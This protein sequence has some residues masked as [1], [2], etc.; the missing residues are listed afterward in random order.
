[1]HAG[2]RDPITLAL[3]R[4]LPS[5]NSIGYIALAV[6]RGALTRRLKLHSSRTFIH[7]TGRRWSVFSIVWPRNSMM[8]KGQLKVLHN[9]LPASYHNELVR[10]TMGKFMSQ[11]SKGSLKSGGIE[12]RNRSNV[13]RYSAHVPPE[14]FAGSGQN[15][16]PRVIT[17]FDII[18]LYSVVDVRIST[19]NTQRCLNGWGGLE[20]RRKM[21][22]LCRAVQAHTPP[23]GEQPN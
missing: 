16:V 7:T 21:D 17:T 12:N 22:V 9:L 6:L 19:S 15:D 3:P 23:S 20:D 11:I 8:C 13:S 4:S 1:M 10:Y 5:M 2:P 14:W 18:V